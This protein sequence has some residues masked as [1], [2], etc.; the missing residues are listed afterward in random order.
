MNHL[1]EI[2]RVVARLRDP[3]LEVINEDYDKNSTENISKL[4]YGFKSGEYQ[5]DQVAAASLYAASPTDTRY[6]TLKTRLKKRLL[7]SLFLLDLKRR[8]YSQYGQSVYKNNKRIFIIK[9]LLSLGVRNTAVRMA[10]SELVEAQT[11]HLTSNAVE[12]L[13][14]LRYHQVVAGTTKK[15]EHY[16]RQLKM[17]LNTLVAECRAMEM[18]ERLSLKIAKKAGFDED[19]SREIQEYV[20]E[21]QFAKTNCDSFAFMIAYY[22]VIQL[23]EMARLDYEAS[24]RNSQDAE[25]YL[26]AHPLLASTLRYG[27]FALTKL[28]SYTK[29]REF[30]KGYAAALR[31]AELF[32]VGSNSWFYYNEDYFLLMMNTLHFAEAETIFT[33]ATGHAR[34]DQLPEYRKEKWKIFDLYLR[35]ALLRDSDANIESQQRTLPRIKT[36]LR[37][38]PSHSKDKQGYNVAVLILQIVFLL[39]S[40]NFNEIIS[41]MEALKTYRGRYL[42]SNSNRQSALFFKLLQIMENNSF[43]YRITIEK[44]KKYQEALSAATGTADINE[45]LLII[46]FDWLWEQILHKLEDIEVR[47]RSLATL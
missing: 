14:I 27:E 41:R 32:P 21:L 9:T 35:Y 47:Q 40:E 29:L 6:T 42:K 34:Y 22:R 38:I 44:S 16:D 2:L 3:K 46:P 20:A 24:I 30:E 18:Y 45:G 26:D 19:D 43:S 36:F 28:S 25:E 37:S 23:A 8:G 7:N 5:N 17:G 10:E 15:F 13:L 1:P 4:Y 39:E 33:M 12:L 11:Y 31:C